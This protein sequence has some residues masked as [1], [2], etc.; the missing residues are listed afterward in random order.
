V[1]QLGELVMSNDPEGGSNMRGA[2]PP[3]LLPPPMI[4]GKSAPSPAETTRF[5]NPQLGSYRQRV[6]GDGERTAETRSTRAP[7]RRA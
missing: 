2:R 3:D 4:Y 6:P 7:E 5:S 1:I